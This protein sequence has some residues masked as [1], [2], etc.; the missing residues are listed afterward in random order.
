L[1]YEI[2][3][4]TI[5]LNL[6]VLYFYQEKV[7]IL[8]LFGC[9]PGFE[10]SPFDRMSRFGGRLFDLTGRGRFGGRPRRRLPANSRPP[11]S[12]PQLIRS[13]STGTH[14]KNKLHLISV[15]DLQLANSNK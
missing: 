10:L 1:L 14:Y 2:N 8:A 6:A 5:Q 12:L 3:N 13:I 7:L 15:P 11:K 9:N 4:L